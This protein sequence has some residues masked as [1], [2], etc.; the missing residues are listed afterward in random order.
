MRKM[1]EEEFDA[2]TP[3]PNGTTKGAEI[4]LRPTA[5]GVD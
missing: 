4:E 1:L 3:E 2:T 5:I